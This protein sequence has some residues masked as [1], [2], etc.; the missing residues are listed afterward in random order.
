MA[1]RHDCS[2]LA[3]RSRFPRGLRYDRQLAPPGCYRH[4]GLLATDLASGDALRSVPANQVVQARKELG[5]GDDF[6]IMPTETLAGLGRNLGAELLASV[7]TRWWA[8]AI[9]VLRVDLR[10]V[11]A[12][13]GEVVA[14]SSTTGTENQIF[15]LVSRA[16]AALRQKLG[17]SEVSPAQALQVEASLPTGHEAAR[18]DAEGWPTCATRTRW[19]HEDPRKSGR[20]RAEAS[21]PPWRAHGGL[22]RARIR[23]EGPRGGAAGCTQRRPAARATTS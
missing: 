2:T 10:I 18:C 4:S 6:T 17:L 5:L 3:T 22:V 7:P 19:R 16:G 8:Q 20:S 15:D 21:R 13:S 23:K 1:R 12:A 9:R 14:S 11:T